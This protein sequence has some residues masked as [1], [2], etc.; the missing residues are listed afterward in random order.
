MARSKSAVLTDGERAIMAVLW[1]EGALPVRDITEALNEHKA[2]AY[3]TV[4]T[5]CKV[6]VDKGY[7]SY[8]KKGRAFIYKAEISRRSAQKSAVKSV[9]N[10]FF[11]G[12][13]TLMAQYLLAEDDFDVRD[14]AA[15]QKKIDEI[16][17]VSDKTS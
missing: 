4:Q 10:H 11:G 1:K 3:T 17:D 2:V 15:L 7:A 14:L 5:M 13:S 8:S 12:S 6:L 16:D 9:M